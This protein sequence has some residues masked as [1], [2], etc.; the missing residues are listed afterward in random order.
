L[1]V[2][3]AVVVEVVGLGEIAGA[4]DV[5]LGVALLAAAGEQRGPGG[6]A[7]APVLAALA[8]ERQSP[9]PIGPLDPAPWLLP[10]FGY[11]CTPST[12]TA[13][14]GLV[15][16]VIK[17]DG[18]AARPGDYLNTATVPRKLSSWTAACRRA[19]SQGWIVGLVVS[20]VSVVLAA[21]RWSS[22]Q[23]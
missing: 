2:G 8:V 16:P 20:I 15:V 17:R 19:R 23:L 21:I 11:G 5:R 14:W 6:A 13:A 3:V 7:L 18:T 9:V 1:G 22:R 4:G 12:L 10:L